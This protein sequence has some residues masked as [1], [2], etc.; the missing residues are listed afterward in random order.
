MSTV[1][2]NPVVLIHVI[3]PVALLICLQTLKQLACKHSRSYLK[4]SWANTINTIAPFSSRLPLGNLVPAEVGLE[5]LPR[6]IRGTCH[7]SRSALLWSRGIKQS[8]PKLYTLQFSTP[9]GVRG[10]FL[11]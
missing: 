11:D 8:S 6:V 1:P 5:F 4:P 10:T 2:L 3:K 9:W 7:Y